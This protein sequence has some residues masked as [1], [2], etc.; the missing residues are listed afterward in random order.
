MVDGSVLRRRPDSGRSRS[1]CLFPECSCS[2]SLRRRGRALLRCRAPPAKH[3]RSARARGIRLD[4]K[5]P[6]ERDVGRGAHVSEGAVNR[7]D[8]TDEALARALEGH[9]TKLLERVEALE[10]D[11]QRLE[12]ERDA[13]VEA[14]DGLQRAVKTLRQGRGAL[15]GLPGLLARSPPRKR[16][17]EGFPTA[18]AIVDVLSRESPLHRSEIV[19]RLTELGFSWGERDPTRVVGITLGRNREIFEEVAPQTFRLRS[20]SGHRLS[21]D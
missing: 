12:L 1:H 21:R 20:S 19:S 4:G 11:L 15:L 3:T 5:S 6:A 7:P 10:A 2:R 14:Y 9:A 13:T 8:P 17:P 18:H 16:F